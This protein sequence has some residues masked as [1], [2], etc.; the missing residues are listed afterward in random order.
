M[1]LILS[2][3]TII[4]PYYFVLPFQKLH[5]EPRRLF[6]KS[7]TS[8]AACHST[9]TNTSAATGDGSLPVQQPQVT[10]ANNSATP[11]LPGHKLQKPIK[12]IVSKNKL[13]GSTS[14]FANL[15]QLQQQAHAAQPLKLQLPPATNLHPAIKREDALHQVNS[16]IFAANGC[17]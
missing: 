16:L 6:K 13:N 10:G 5:D 1:E 12:L 3:Q 17:N 15:Q 7:H 11:S 2:S 4:S 9:T 14:P 8:R